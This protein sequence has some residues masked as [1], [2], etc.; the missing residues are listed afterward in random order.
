MKKEK[1]AAFKKY[2]TERGTTPNAVLSE[3]VLSCIKDEETT[4]DQ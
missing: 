2:C 1:V 3:F 4:D